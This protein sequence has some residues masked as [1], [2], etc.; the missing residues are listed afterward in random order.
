MSDLDSLVDY[1]VRLGEPYLTKDMMGKY[2]ILRDETMCSKNSTLQGHDLI[3]MSEVLVDDNPSDQEIFK[4]KLKGN[5]RVSKFLIGHQHRT[6]D[7]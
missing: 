3:F 4:Y 6:T 5:V 1:D 2:V 7:S